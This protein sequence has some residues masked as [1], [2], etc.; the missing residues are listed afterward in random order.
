MPLP[1]PLPLEI[2]RAA[3]TAACS[4]Y[5]IAADLVDDAA[6]RAGA[7]AP[8]DQAVAGAGAQA[9]RTR[10]TGHRRWTLR[11]LLVVGQVAVA[12]VL[13]V[14]ALLFLRNLARAHDLDPGFDT[15]HTLVAQVG[16][17]EGRYTPDDAD[18]WLERRRS[19]GCARCRASRPRATPTAR[20]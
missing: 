6:V 8:G 15:A 4:L 9:G 10:A 12:L 1:L 16:F 20:R 3:S 11:G 14:T 5:S 18:G 7:G 13:L 2:A 19:S 17:V